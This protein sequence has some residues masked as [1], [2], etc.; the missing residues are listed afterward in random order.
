MGRKKNKKNSKSKKKNSSKTI[1]KIIIFL[2]VIG[3][4]SS[5]YLLQDHS[6][7]AT[8]GSF[9]DIT[10]KISC[11]LV[12]SSTYSELFNVPVAMFGALWCVILGLLAFRAIK[13][14]KLLQALLGWSIPGMLFIG[15]MIIAEFILGALCPMCTVVHAIV[16]ITF[17]L[18]LYLYKNLPNNKKVISMKQLFNTLKPWLA[19][20]VILNLIPLI[21]Y[22]LPERVQEDH[23]QVAKCITESGVNMYG[24]FRCGVCAK[25][26][27][28]FGDSFEHIN[29]IECHPQGENPQTELCL[30]KGIEGTPTWILEPN[31][32]EVKRQTGFLSIEELQEFSGCEE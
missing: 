13:N 15:Y 5:L 23:T 18:I 30:E 24:S 1:L 3:L 11:S 32:V 12:N 29:E 7:S 16:L 6:S 4:F 14:E 31:G 21:V 10:D 8:E 28:M 22:N 17:I 25:T 19:V 27:A 20:I 26:R 9:C 2:S